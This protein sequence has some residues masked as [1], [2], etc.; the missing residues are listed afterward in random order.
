MIQ[1]CFSVLREIPSALNLSGE[2][3]LMSPEPP[4]LLPFLVQ[5]SEE[6]IF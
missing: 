1:V 3:L 5:I 6:L 4:E 2:I